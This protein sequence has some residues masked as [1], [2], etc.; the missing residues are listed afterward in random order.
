MQLELSEQSINIIMEALANTPYRVSAGVI[1]DIATQ[2]QAQRQQ[3][4]QAPS[5]PAA[6]P[7]AGNGSAPA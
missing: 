5:V 1:N 4:I 3:A 2:V 7:H 6:Q